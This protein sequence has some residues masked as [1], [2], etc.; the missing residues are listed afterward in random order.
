[1]SDLLSDLVA[2]ALKEALDATGGAG[3]DYRSA[4]EA[5]LA[6]LRSKGLTCVPK[7]PSEQMLD[8]AWAYALNEDA[9]GVWSSMIK[10]FEQT[11]HLQQGNSKQV[12]GSR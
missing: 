1:M 9:A 4:A 6:D 12:Q 5:F 3:T 11:Q 10:E 2:S 7:T 8:A